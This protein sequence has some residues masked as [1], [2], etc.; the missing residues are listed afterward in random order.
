[1]RQGKTENSETEVAELRARLEE[2]EETLRAIRSGEVDAL[3]VSGEGEERIFT[4]QG[5][6][7]PYRVLVEEMNEGAVTLVSDGTVI[8]A[9]R[10]F[11]QM[12][13]VPLERLI[14]ASLLDFLETTSNPTL[15]ALL[16]QIEHFP[17][18]VKGRLSRTDDSVIPVSLSFSEL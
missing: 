16:Q 18:K 13:G 14:G 11:S 3:V 7:H 8:Y 12:L 10:R 9:N 15:K 5:A 6:E 17:L 1:M 2:L 4:L